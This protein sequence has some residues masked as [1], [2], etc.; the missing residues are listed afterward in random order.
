MSTLRRIGPH[1]VTNYHCIALL[2]ADRTNAQVWRWHIFRA[3][4]LPACA[5]QSFP[6][7][8]HTSIL[9]MI[10]PLKSM[11]GTVWRSVS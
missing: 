5:M 4:S 11:L 7:D 2:A 1:I 8:R 6:C 9:K 10:R 3:D